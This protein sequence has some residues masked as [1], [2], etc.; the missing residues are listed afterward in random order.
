MALRGIRVAKQAQAAAKNRAGRSRYS[1]RHTPTVGVPFKARFRGLFRMPSVV[2][3][4]KEL[5]KLDR[6]DLVEVVRD[7][8]AVYRPSMEDKDVVQSILER[9][10]QIEPVLG[11]RHYCER[12]RGRKDGVYAFINC[13]DQEAAITGDVRTKTDC[14]VCEA[15]LGGD[16]GVSFGNTGYY[17]SAYI[18]EH[19]HQI[20]KDDKKEY[21][22]CVLDDDDSGGYCKH[23][24]HNEEL[25]DRPQEEIEAIKNSKGEMEEM[26]QLV[27]RGYRR[28]LPVAMRMLDLAQKF[29]LG[30]LDVNRRLTGRCRSCGTGKLKKVG[31]Y[32]PNK[33]CKEEYEWRELLHSGWNPDDPQEIECPFCEK[34][35]IP[36]ISYECNE[37]EDAVPS[38]LC[39][40][41]VECCM[42]G[43][44]QQKTWT[45]IE[46][47][48]I[49]PLDPEDED[50]LKVLAAPL[51][52]YDQELKAPSEEEQ[53]KYLGVSARSVASAPTI[54]K[55]KIKKGG[56]FKNAG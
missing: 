37:C 30:L 45:F 27:K 24:E 16:K 20:V 7:L 8:Q 54:G 34:D 44:R 17:F 39:D 35:V 2:Y 42:L 32:C 33:L 14:K 9:Y 6:D 40:T 50:D 28:R 31:A 18:H 23:C 4:E 47:Y 41:I 52:N 10:E 36:A 56:Y 21:V 53:L 26:A 19:Q 49:C 12:N 13:G 48:P 43:E 22:R 46:Q 5:Q 55:K 15:K 11:A 25:D 3:T 1:R 29:A 51:P 38:Q